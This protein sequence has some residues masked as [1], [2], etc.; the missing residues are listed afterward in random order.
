MSAAFRFLLFLALLASYSAGNAQSLGERL[1]QAFEKAANTT[2]AAKNYGKVRR[3]AKGAK[4]TLVLRV[5]IDRYTKFW[6]I[7]A[8]VERKHDLRCGLRDCSQPLGL[9]KAGVGIYLLLNRNDEYGELRTFSIS[10]LA[11]PE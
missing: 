2:G 5:G 3:V 1:G 11:R 10:A 9:L 7:R 8:S 4:P 6:E